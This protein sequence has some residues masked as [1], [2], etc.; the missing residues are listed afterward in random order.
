MIPTVWVGVAL[1][2]YGTADVSYSGEFFGWYAIPA[3]FV[4]LTLGLATMGNAALRNKDV[5]PFS[6]LLLAVAASG[7]LWFLVLLVGRDV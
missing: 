3:A 1:G 2:L 5:G 7:G 6:F 4:L